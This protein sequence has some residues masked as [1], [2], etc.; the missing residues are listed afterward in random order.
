[1]A[2]VAEPLPVIVI[3]EL[4]G[5]PVE[6]QAQFKP[7][8]STAIARII[9]PDVTPDMFEHAIPAIMGFVQYFSGL[10]EQR[11]ADPRD[12]LLTA[13]DRRRGRGRLARPAGAAWP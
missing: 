6:D 8:S 10:I 9:D 7:W 12:D 1:M 2:D 13:A 11:R 3:C 5:V 4:L